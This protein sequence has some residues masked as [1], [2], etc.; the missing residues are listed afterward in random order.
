M[1]RPYTRKNTVRLAGRDYGAVGKYFITICTKWRAPW[2]G[3]IHDGRMFLN[4]AGCVA[5]QCWRDIP[6]HFPH[7]IPDAFV[8]MPD[9]VHGIITIGYDRDM[10]VPH[11]GTG[12]PRVRA[13]NFAPLPP[14]GNRFGPQSRNLASIIR[15][16]KIGVTLG[17]RKCGYP[18]FQWQPRFHDRIIRDSD[19]YEQIRRYI[20]L[21]PSRWKQK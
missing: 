12:E 11:M 5:D 21:N 4:A 7:V 15:G 9:H 2:F 14:R 6:T 10:G 17:A 1:E 8:I 3:S 16:F 13:Q 18:E 19:A 20:A